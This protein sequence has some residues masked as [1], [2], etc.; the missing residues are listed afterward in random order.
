VAREVATTIQPLVEKNGNTLRLDLRPELGRMRSDPMKIRQVLLNLLSNACKF[1]ERGTITLAATRQAEEHGDWIALEVRDTGMG[2]TSDQ[3]RRIFEAFSQADSSISRKY[4]GTGLGLAITRKFCQM[5]GG[6]VGA[7]SDSGRGS[8]FRVRLP[9]IVN[10]DK[11]AAAGAESAEAGAPGT[12]SES[13]KSERARDRRRSDAGG[14]A[15]VLVVD[16]DPATRDLMMQILRREGYRAVAAADG[17]EGIRKARELRPAAITLDVIM[18][19]KDGWAV[20]GEIKADPELAGI[21]VIMVTMLDDSN[22]GYALGASEFVTKPVDRARLLAVLAKYRSGLKP[23]KV[24]VVED[25]ADTRDM[26]GR[27]LSREGWEVSSAE[28]GRAALQR[29]QAGMPDLI[30]LDLMMPE[31]DGFEFVEHL[32]HGGSAVDV[33]IIVITAKELTEEDR[34][35][36]NHSVK[37]ILQKGAHTQAEI[38]KAIGDLLRTNAPTGQR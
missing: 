30:L 18:P 15:T 26:L 25:D 19:G 29:L 35:R 16:D 3:L 28:N 36:L 2:M 13:G 11:D 1:T 38:L 9:A 12:G 4:G 34:Q 22:L 8:T 6:D 23:G 32:R 37:R 27:I 10:P 33:P 5:M 20:L 14:G 17:E 21:P 24:L 31:M 7:E